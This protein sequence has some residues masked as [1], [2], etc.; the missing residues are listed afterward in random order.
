VLWPVGRRLRESEALVDDADRQLGI[1]PVDHAR[2]L[3]LAGR[4]QLDVDALVG[5]Q[6]EHRLGDAG[7][8][9]HAHP[10]DRD[11]ADLVVVAD[12]LAVLAD[13]LGDLVLEQ[14]DGAL[15]VD[16]GQRERQVRG[17]VVGLVLHDHVDRD[18][19]VGE[20]REHPRGDAGRIRQVFDRDL[21]LVARRG[22]TG[23]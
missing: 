2:D 3:D 7:V 22:D 4:D 21:R 15:A 23:D 10:D 18:V 1:F 6:R 11:L 16:L 5:E 8:R 13:Q 19:G 12:A 14:L 9:A 17:A 20:R